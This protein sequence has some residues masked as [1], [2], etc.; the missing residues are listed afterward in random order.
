MDNTS[1][2][3]RNSIFTRLL[4]VFVLVITPVY[5]GGTR[6]YTWGMQSIE[7]KISN[8]MVSQLDYYMD[9]LESDIRNINEL[10]L[11]LLYDEDINKLAS[12]SSS[13]NNIERTHAIKRLQRR[14]YTIKSSSDYIKNV[15]VHI[16]SIDRT[17]YA[18]SS[19]SNVPYDTFYELSNSHTI[20][21]S[22]II[23]YKN[24]LYLRR[25]FRYTLSL[26][27]TTLCF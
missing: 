24:V 1:I 14:L 2:H 4:L 22:Q 11:D 15:S 6:L 21:E 12:I 18:M 8:S 27:K 26:K 20:T 10:K 9:S 25:V 16:P 7:K 5:Y 23:N 3:W 17:I 13:L 19:I